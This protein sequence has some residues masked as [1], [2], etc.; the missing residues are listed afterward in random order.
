MTDYTNNHGVPLTMAV[1]L[2]IDEYDHNDDPNVISASAIIRPLK[3]LV[4]SQRVPKDA[5][6]PDVSTMA[7]S[8]I[9]TAIHNS[10]EYSWVEKY[11]EGLKSLGYKDKIIDRIVVNPEE[12]TDLTNK[13]PIY[14]EQRVEK[15]F[16]GKVISGKYDVI[17]DGTIQDIKSTSTFTYVNKTNDEKY[18]LQMS[19]YRW[20]NPEKITSDHGSILY[21][22]TDWSA[23]RASDPNYPSSKVMEY[24]IS[25]MSLEETENYI[26]SKIVELGTYINAEEDLIPEC[27]DEDLWRKPPTWKYYKNPAKRTRATKNFTSL[28]DANTRLSED[29]NVGI[30]VE[31][32]G[33]V[34]ACKY[35][36]AAPVCK[37]KDRYI[38]DGTLVL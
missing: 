28:I 14:L 29:G 17:A 3:E 4:L 25:L 6:P 22:F 23:G 37:Q 20:L 24:K 5:Y 35:C 34:N 30:V 2:A 36:S 1:W 9:G 10:V 8:R 26:R 38:A 33:T 13:I 21:V 16:M 19:I 15:E 18:R 32:P 27:S 7:A 31:V 11:K 12:G